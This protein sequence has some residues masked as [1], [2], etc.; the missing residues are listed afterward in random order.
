MGTLYMVCTASAPLL[1]LLKF[2]LWR[3]RNKGYPGRL[4]QDGH[5]VCPHVLLRHVCP[6]T[7]EPRGIPDVSRRRGP[8]VRATRTLDVVRHL[9]GRGNKV[10]HPPRGASF[11]GNG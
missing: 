11:L 2:Q 5:R 1:G 4:L 3:F 10:Q 9:G 8:R 7:L 6:R